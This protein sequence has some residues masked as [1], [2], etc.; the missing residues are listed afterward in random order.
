[1]RRHIKFLLTC[2]KDMSSSYRLARCFAVPEAAQE[3]VRRVSGVFSRSD[4]EEKA[5]DTFDVLVCGGTLGVFI[6]TALSLKGLRV[7]IVEKNVLKG[8]N[9]FNNRI[10]P[11]FCEKV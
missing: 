8:V 11:R 10:H 1:M 7:G 9:I 2:Q 5:I 3:V 6:A 4:L